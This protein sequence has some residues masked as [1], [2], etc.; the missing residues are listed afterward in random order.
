MYT[1]GGCAL[2]TTKVEATFLK[3]GKLKVSEFFLVEPKVVSLENGT[4][5]LGVHRRVMEKMSLT[6]DNIEE[7]EYG[8]NTPNSVDEWI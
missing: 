1:F 8:E 6:R 7:R 4:K 2:C 3:N 5:N